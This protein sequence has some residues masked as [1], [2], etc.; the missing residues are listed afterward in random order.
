MDSILNNDVNSVFSDV[1]PALP[2]WHNVRP[3]ADEENFTQR[4]EARRNLFEEARMN[5]QYTMLD[6]TV[7]A[8]LQVGDLDKVKIKIQRHWEFLAS[9][10]PDF[11]SQVTDGILDAVRLWRQGTEVKSGKRKAE[12]LSAESS[13]AAP[14]TPRPSRLLLHDTPSP[15]GLR[16]NRRLGTPQY[17]V[18]RSDSVKILTKKRDGNL[19]AISRMGAVDVAHIYPWCAFGEKQKKTKNFWQTLAMFWPA[20]KVNAWREK[21][22]KDSNA[23]HRAT[24]TVENML[25]LTATLHRFHSD[26]AFALRP[27][28]M[29]DDKKQ[30][31]LEFHWLVMEDREKNQKV[32]LLDEPLSSANLERSGKGY[33]PFFRPDAKDDQK[34]TQLRSGDTIR[35]STDDPVKMPLPDPGLLE[36]QWHLQ[37]IL[38]M[39]GAAG[40]REE[41][42]DDDDDDDRTGV[43]NPTGVKHW[44]DDFPD[45]PD[46]KRQHQSSS[47][48]DSEDSMDGSS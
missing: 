39:S 19:C 29:S 27:I 30:L 35:L 33:G 1:D 20:E 14:E 11:S 43:A 47:T 8:F 16:P 23:Q 21:L 38:A 22:F 13:T 9:D 41:D 4:S 3:E 18:N 32:D 10:E 25:S 26:G 48:D 17:S 24:E 44:L 2:V 6:P 31:E 40:W 42:F 12:M 46:H 7:W 28:Q 34:F 37:R 5:G 45:L 36:L 15:L